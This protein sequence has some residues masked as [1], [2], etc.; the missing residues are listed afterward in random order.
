MSFNRFA[1][2]DGTGMHGYAY[3]W[4]FDRAPRIGDVVRTDAA[5]LATVVGFGTEFT[6]HLA[7]L[8]ELTPI[9]RLRDGW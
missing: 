6:G 9:N 7:A 5:V 8:V 4:P 1:R 2:L 3:L